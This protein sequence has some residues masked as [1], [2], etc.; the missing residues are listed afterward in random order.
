MSLT[1]T[2]VATMPIDAI[3]RIK[4]AKSPNQKLVIVGTCMPNEA[5]SS[6]S[7]KPGSY[8]HASRL[9][10]SGVWRERTGM[11]IGAISSKLAK[12][13]IPS[14]QTKTPSTIQTKKLV[15]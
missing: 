11:P 1:E 4:Q 7:A 6:T 12:S 15:N 9:P 13:S 8:T 14:G 5:N 2:L 10:I 3:H